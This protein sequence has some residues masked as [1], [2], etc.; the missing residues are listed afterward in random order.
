MRQPEKS[1]DFPNGAFEPAQ[2][3]AGKL[4]GSIR[5]CLAKRDT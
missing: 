2:S 5:V 3:G 4:P 1:T